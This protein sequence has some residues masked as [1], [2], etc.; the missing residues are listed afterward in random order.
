MASSR[1]RREPYSGSA[2][3][4]VIGI[5]VGTTFSGVSYAIL[6]PGEVPEVVSITQSVRHNVYSLLSTLNQ[7]LSASRFSGQ[8]IMGAKIPSVIFYDENSQI[9]AIGPQTTLDS[10]I[11]ESELNEWTKVEQYVH[12][13]SAAGKG[14]RLT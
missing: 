4:I 11:Q 9:K 3:G 7:L 6:R 12:N 8:T 10:I 5:D 2:T 14:C 13:S 1:L